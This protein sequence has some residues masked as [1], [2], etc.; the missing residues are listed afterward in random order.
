MVFE[1]VVVIDARE[2][3]LGRLASVVAKEILNGQKVVVVRCE[4]INVSGSFIRNKLKYQMYLTKRCLVRPSHGPFHFRA[5]SRMLYRVVRGMIPHKMARGAAA[6]DRLKVFDGIPAPYDKMKRVVIPS[7][8]RALR[9]AP[10]RKY[11]DLGRLAHEVGWKYQD[12]LA[13]LEESR[14]AKSKVFYE[15]KKALNKLRVKAINNKKTALAP[16]Q[17]KLAQYGH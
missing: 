3:L 6:L 9:L 14:K 5:P 11:C 7:A 17:K 8:L 10:K 13:T 4:K 16:V 1:K 12:V 2:H 15:R